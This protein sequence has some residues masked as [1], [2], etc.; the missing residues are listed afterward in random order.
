MK[1]FL[2]VLLCCLH[3]PHDVFSQTLLPLLQVKKG[4]RYISTFN[5]KPFFW[6]GDTAWELLHRLTLDEARTYLE[7]R[8]KKG[9]NVVLAVANAEF[10]GMRVPNRNG[11][12]A[13]NDYNP[14]KP[15]ERY[16]LHVD[17]VVTLAAQLG[18]YIALL[19]TWG[20]KLSKKWDPGPEIFTP[21]NAAAYGAYLAGRYRNQNIIW[22]LGGDRDPE[23]EQHL[24]IIQAMASGIRKVAGSSQL[25][26]Y[27]PTGA[28]HSSRY[29][30]D[31]DW[32]DFNIFQSGHSIRHQKNYKMVRKDY[33]KNPPRPTL[34]AEPRYEN[35]PVNWKPELGYFND[36]D[37][38]QAA[39]WAFLSGAAGHTYGCHDV[40]Q[41]YDNTRNKPMGFARTNWQVAMDLPGATHM[42]FLKKLAESYSWQ[43]L[44]PAQQLILNTNPEDAGYQVAACSADKDFAFIYSP[45]GHGVTVDLGVF[46]AAELA[47][48]WYNPRDGSSLLIGKKQNRG[49][50]TF[51]PDIA[52]PET[53]W[54]LVIADAKNS[55]PGTTVKK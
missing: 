10:E 7:D 33:G 3:A 30:H 51:Q 13:M 42:G 31:A 44:V 32:L 27:H 53:D 48:Y 15:N 23:N 21:E 37:V 41:M 54:V 50:V 16:F 38:R 22:V 36:F 1:Q 25:I 4:E 24:A 14:A 45:Y 40:W 35:H 28:S 6:L 55:Q 34:D 9:F 47:V 26:T 2:L 52:G 49:T 20:D 29:F 5:E 39:W 11:D 12:L 46:N 8:S 19:P 18:I 43:K 17:S